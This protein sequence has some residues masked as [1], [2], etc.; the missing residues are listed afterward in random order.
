MKEKHPRFKEV[1]DALGS[2]SES[3]SGARRASA[4]EGL[5][6]D[7]LRDAGVDDE[8]VAMMNAVSP[9]AGSRLGDLA[10]ELSPDGGKLSGKTVKEWAGLLDIDEAEAK[11][12][13]LDVSQGTAEERGEKLMK[14][15]KEGGV[16]DAESFGEGDV[17]GKSTR[18]TQEAYVAANEAFVQS[19]HAFVA[20]LSAAKIPGV[21]TVGAADVQEAGDDV[22]AEG[23]NGTNNG[24]PSPG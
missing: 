18:G 24:T 23:G 9:G 10:K 20:A 11:K 17:G 4:M 13:L 15:V 16:M 21:P 6:G 14:L 7:V 22:L 3:T 5:F 8:E 2:A 19:V 1:L 12:R